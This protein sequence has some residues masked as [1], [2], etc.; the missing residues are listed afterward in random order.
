MSLLDTYLPAEVVDPQEDTTQDSDINTLAK[1][2]EFNEA[3][4]TE[5]FL[6][7]DMNNWLQRKAARISAAINDAFRTLTTF[8]F[9]RPEVINVGAMR[10]ILATRDYTDLTELKVYIPVGF[11]GSLI[12]YVQHLSTQGQGL[13]QRL[14]I[15]LLHPMQK[16]LSHYINRPGDSMDSRELM[17]A[18]KLSL[19]ELS[20]VKSQTAEFFIAGNRR[21]T[22]D[23]GNVFGN[24]N[25]IT[26]T[27]ERLNQLNASLWNQV[28]PELVEKETQKIVSL[29]TTLMGQLESS[30]NNTSPEFIKTITGLIGMTGQY[31]E[32]YAALQT[33]LADFTAAMKLN[34]KIL[35]DIGKE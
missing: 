7:G 12:D 35:L 27:A 4:A 19:D 11:N 26:T 25:E 5:A 28:R 31:V 17:F 23:L 29:A 2:L 20:T 33:Q 34:E 3:V 6:V 14:V 32:W 30:D 9:E 16:C 15:E 24:K 22:E 8:N 10:R 1:L 18:P 13:A 21:T